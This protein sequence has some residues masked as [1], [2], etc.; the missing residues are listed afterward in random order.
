MD[1]QCL[2]KGDN[3]SETE[4]FIQ[5]EWIQKREMALGGPWGGRSADDNAPLTQ[6]IAGSVSVPKD[7]VM[8]P[9]LLRSGKRY[10]EMREVIAPEG[11]NFTTSKKFEG[12]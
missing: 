7:R 9:P 5:F 2:T 8:H 1:R 10:I 12:S 6:I 11:V 3:P 4:P